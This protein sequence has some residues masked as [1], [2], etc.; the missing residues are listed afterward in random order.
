CWLGAGLPLAAAVVAIGGSALAF[1]VW[2][3]Q[4]AA[5]NRCLGLA[6]L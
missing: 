5:L 6:A 2:R 1:L 3:C 4:G